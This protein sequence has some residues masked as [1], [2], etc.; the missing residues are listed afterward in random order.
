[1]TNAG[2]KINF[3]SVFQLLSLNCYNYSSENVSHA[4]KLSGSAHAQVIVLI[5]KYGTT[6]GELLWD[7]IFLH[8]CFLGIGMRRWTSI[9]KLMTNHVSFIISHT[10]RWV[11]KITMIIT[12][13]APHSRIIH[14]HNAGR[15]GLGCCRDIISHKP[16]S[17][18]TG[19]CHCQGNKNL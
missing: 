12:N 15:P 8:C 18:R 13:V 9:S 14:L 1:M 5:S 3:F 7:Y 10:S 17:S 2:L 16:Q 6:S 4:V 19:R 11:V